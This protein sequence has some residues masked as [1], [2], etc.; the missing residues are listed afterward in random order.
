MCVSPKQWHHTCLAAVEMDPFLKKNPP[1][2][3]NSLRKEHDVL[4]PICVEVYILLQHWFLGLSW[5]PGSV[6]CVCLAVAAA[7]VAAAWRSSIPSSRW[8][9]KYWGGLSRWELLP[10]PPHIRLCLH[11]CICVLSRMTCSCL[12]IFWCCLINTLSPVHHPPR[13]LFGIL[14]CAFLTWRWCVC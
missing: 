14:S 9:P 13:H 12:C 7:A 2:I 8:K 5:W 10:P 4:A 1:K 3:L 11:L 6:V